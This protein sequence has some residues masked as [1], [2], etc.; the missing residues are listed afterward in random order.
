MPL[1]LLEP[2]R[3]RP[4]NQHSLRPFSAGTGSVSKFQ[5][6]RSGVLAMK[7]V[8]GTF[9]ESPSLWPPAQSGRCEYPASS[10]IDGPQGRSPPRT[11]PRQRNPRPA[12]LLILSETANFRSF[13]AN[14]AR[15]PGV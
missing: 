6:R 10:A 2:P 1:M 14:H 15:L 5:L 12:P 8:P 3:M 11:L 13:R 7:A 9:V 4:W